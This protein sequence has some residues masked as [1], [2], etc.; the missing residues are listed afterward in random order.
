[1]LIRDSDSL[2]V[3][4]I[5]YN[6][7]LPAENVKI[8]TWRPRLM[9]MKVR[10]VPLLLLTPDKSWEPSRVPWCS[11]RMISPWKLQRGVLAQVADFKRMLTAQNVFYQLSS[12]RW[13]SWNVRASG[14]GDGLSFQI[15]ICRWKKR[16]KTS[17]Q[18]GSSPVC[19]AYH[20]STNG[21]VKTRRPDSL[22]VKALYC[23]RS[24]KRAIGGTLF[25]RDLDE[26]EQLRIWSG[27]LVAFTEGV[28]NGT[29][30]MLCVTIPISCPVCCHNSRRL[31][32]WSIRRC[33]NYAK[34]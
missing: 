20:W 3:P 6:F 9:A 23:K 12:V 28:D 11:R 32:R 22:E 31:S 33:S 25:W 21:V 7:T 18:K 10:L 19:V 24:L 13:S 26:G 29:V 5:R 2:V 30:L 34:D 14:V 16:L 17:L 8:P 4:Q 15:A 1:M 27:C